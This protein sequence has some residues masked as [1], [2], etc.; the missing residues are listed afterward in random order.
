MRYHYSQNGQDSIANTLAEAKYIVIKKC[1][2]VTGAFSL[3]RVMILS[4][5]Y[6][7]Y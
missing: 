5:A 3:I 2:H 1:L 4:P 6:L 7:V